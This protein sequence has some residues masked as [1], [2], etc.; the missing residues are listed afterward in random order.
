MEFTINLKG[1]VMGYLEEFQEQI[2]NRDFSKFLQLWE[3]YCTSDTVEV[4]EF[5]QLLQSIKQSDFAKSFGKFIETAL[6]LWQTIQN[7]DDRYRILKLLIDLQNTNTPVLAETTLNALKEKYGNQPQF[8]ERL[9]LVGLRSRENFQGA[10]SNYDLLSHMEKGNFVFHTGGW[11]TGE[12]TDVS[13]VREQVS[14]EFENVAGRKHLT[15]ANAFKTLIPLQNDNF[16]VR[17]FADPDA[18]EKEARENP[19]QVIK[20]LL[21]DLG[22]KN[23]SE[24]K[25]EL[26][27][28]VIP[29]KDWTKWWQG[30]RTRLKKDT[31]IEAPENL[32]EPF[33]L[34]KAELSQEERLHKAI[35]DKKGINELILTSYN[36]VRDLP[37]VRKNQEVKNS[38]KEK[39]LD[40]LKDSEL[41][42]EQELQIYIFLENMF[43][44]QIE[45]KTAE[46]LIRIIKDVEKVINNIEIV[47]FKKRAL[48][49]VHDFRQDW[50][51]IFLSMFF[52]VPQSLIK[53]YILK[54]LN[55]GATKQLLV[56]KLQELLNNPTAYP[57]MFV[58]YFQKI[59]NK[60]E[61][62][63]PF[64]DKNGQ[65]QFFDGFLI[66][67]SYIESKPE[68]RELAK[69]M[70]NLLSGKRYAIVRAIIEGTSL[71]FIK[72]FL[73]LVSK[74]QTLSDHDIKILR[75]LAEVVHP[76]LATKS[77]KGARHSDSNV[78]WTT[79]KGYFKT[80]DR[81]KQIGTVEVIENAR[82]IEAARALGDLRENSEYKF[83]LE[84]RSRLQGELKMLS[85]QLNRARIITKEDIHA[86]E[87]GVGSVV[88]VVDSQGKVTTYTLLG[89]WDAD[90]EAHT[91]SF[92]SKLA[93]AM[94]GC[95]EGDTF[96]F[97]DEEFT[98]KSIRSF[99]DK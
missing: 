63:L 61:E 98:I 82:E 15:F 51:Q 80:Q 58:W 70:Y 9:K 17:R 41:T 56:N 10:L 93:Q 92:Q 52:S 49:L 32:R 22:P 88:D 66:L 87:V 13:S 16:L 77:H 81:I 76:S 69:K 47:A 8:N 6:P 27:E 97:R 54:E 86:D 78:I 39:L 14:I 33:R 7:Q 73:L 3:E 36:F 35:H 57:E 59:V 26:S 50:T 84:R 5:Q 89:P 24:I 62:E 34:R 55:Q 60:D 79:E 25:D 74:C 91:L 19:V 90:P 38:L 30:A 4:E 37:N 29:E 94:T 11:G 64:S 44:H 20:L 12:I 99:L 48:T 67:F 43:S 40:L 83:A 45:G 68:Y 2:N 75:S 96:Q 23:A 85:E 42:Q 46:N 71:E 28:L 18:L 1:R 53:D 31:I 65:C 72:E 21:R 95:K